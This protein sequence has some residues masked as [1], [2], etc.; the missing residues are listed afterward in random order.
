MAMDPSRPPKERV[1]LLL[2]GRHRESWLSLGTNLFIMALIV[3]NVATFIAG[4]VSWIGARYGQLFAAFDVFAVGVFTVEYLL[5]VW[6]CTV[7]ERY[8]SPIRGRIRFMLSPYALIDLIAIFPFYLP[9]VLGEQG[10]ERMLRIFR[11]FR[12]L[13]IARYSNSLTLITNVFRRKSEELLITV[14][15][16]SIWLVFVSSLMYYVE[17]AAQP[18][19]FSSIPA[20]IWWGIVTL[21]TVGYG[22]V[23]PVT[24]VGR[25]L[26][27]TVALLGIALFALPAGIVASGFVEE[28]ERRRQ[29]PQY[30]P[31]CGEEVDDL[32]DEPPK[33]HVH[34]ELEQKQ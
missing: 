21:T 25:A 13:K 3:L 20:A 11:L 18:E 4:T 22:D 31:H 15:V 7:D 8:S 9:I 26:G 17:R 6:S 2:D 1:Y 32:I 24:P 33:S 23:V 27:A 10:A 12:L 28:L 16:M 29:G 30:C 14:L 19:V 5:R 34:D